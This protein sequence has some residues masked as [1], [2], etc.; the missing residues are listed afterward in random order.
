MGKKEDLESLDK[1]IRES[2]IR[3]HT[4][5][6]HIVSLTNDI[7][8]FS[9]LE[10]N[11][12][13]NIKYLKKNKVIT[14]AESYRKAKDDLAK[15]VIKVVSLMNDREALKKEAR[16]HQFL[17]ADAQKKLDKLQKYNVLQGNFGRKNGK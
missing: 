17:M 10:G 13:D 3:L 6:A 12:I 8:A 1:T 15:T 7:E 14:G 11:L 9:Q 5:Q 16:T 2:N 4:V